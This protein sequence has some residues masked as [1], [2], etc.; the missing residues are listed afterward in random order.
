VWKYCYNYLIWTRSKPTGGFSANVSDVRLSQNRLNQSWAVSCTETG[1]RADL[2]R[3]HRNVNKMKGTLPRPN[4]LITSLPHQ[5][6]Q[7]HRTFSFTYSALVFCEQGLMKYQ[8][9]SIC[10]RE[11][12]SATKSNARKIIENVTWSKKKSWAK[13]K[14]L[15]LRLQHI[16]INDG[17]EYYWIP[18]CQRPCRQH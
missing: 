3:L 1:G 7:M 18:I 10:V 4:L 17:G 16:I 15:R 2:N 13:S 12:N 6:V 14:C 11:W 5:N 9:T 8:G